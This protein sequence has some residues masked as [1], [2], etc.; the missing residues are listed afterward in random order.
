MKPTREESEF[1]CKALNAANLP[2]P[3]EI[4]IMRQVLAG[5]AFDEVLDLGW[6]PHRE[7]FFL[8]KDASLV[9][10][11]NDWHR[12]ALRFGPDFGDRS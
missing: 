11:L 4:E 12:F 3:V 2:A 1:F 9:D 5:R 6:T 7:R 8:L 10:L